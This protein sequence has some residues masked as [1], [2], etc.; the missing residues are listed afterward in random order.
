[1]PSGPTKPHVL[2]EASA[3]AQ[4]L[5]N[6]RAQP[7]G[8]AT[9]ADLN[10]PEPFLKRVANRVLQLSFQEN[11]RVVVA[12]AP[13]RV[14]HEVWKPSA[15][16]CELAEVRAD[17]EGADAPEGPAAMPAARGFR[18][19][20]LGG[21]DGQAR[22]PA[23][24]PAL[25]GLIAL[26]LAREGLLATAARAL[27]L[28]PAGGDDEAALAAAGLPVDLL[29]HFDVDGVVGARAVLAWLRRE[30]AGAPASAWT[31]LLKRAAFRFRPTSPG[32]RAAPDS[33]QHAP[34]LVRLQ[35]SRA[36]YWI[37][38]GDGGSIDVLRQ[39]LESETAPV[40]ASVEA[41]HV[42]ELRRAVADW[43]AEVRSRIRLAVQ[44]LPVSQWAQDAAKWGADGGGP[45]TLM[46]RYASRGE[47]VSLYVPGDTYLAR[48]L[49]KAGLRVAHSP[50]LF[51]GGNLLMVQEPS[52]RRVLLA[53]EAEVLRNQSLGLS[54]D[55]AV[56][57]LSAELGADKCVV[58]PAA[59]IHIDYE[60]SCRVA[61]GRVVAFVLDTGA[62]A[63]L[64]VEAGIDLLERRGHLEA[65]EAAVA[66]SHLAA[67][68]DA[69]CAAAVWKCLAAFS[70]GPGKF[71]LPFAATLRAG[72]Q[73]SGVGNLHRVMAGLD[74]LMSSSPGAIERV[75]DVNHRV[76][77]RS[78]SRRAEDRAS[79]RA[80]LR[81]L[82]WKVVPV[83]G[84][85]QG[86]R[87]INPLNGLHTPW[88]FLMPVY[89]GL[90]AGLDAAAAGV[91]RSALGEDVEVCPVR[92]SESQ[93]RDGALRCSVA[94]L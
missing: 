45:V 13:G 76:Y 85:G 93:R 73:D 56:A 84:I 51:Q 26:R 10:L 5:A 79:L 72:E 82:G 50:L 88:A 63:R 57:A 9:V 59:S 39:V 28:L 21:E 64:V 14:E 18:P 3:E 52:G 77:L 92:T 16:A 38:P 32:F 23:G 65:P 80:A 83:P 70:V 48:G 19:A 41:R 11:F 44:D 78:L 62:G 8:P 40:L 67:G 94:L 35:L 61:D 7:V 60:V 89:G 22:T 46:P 81:N 87:S 30:V 74:L 43:P 42:D 12:D 33:G 86:D 37:G 54:R 27:A 17:V 75:A 29:A 20:L 31:R 6:V 34:S 53:G 91:V 49:V 36:G 4:V 1:M 2:Q 66:R 15:D 55:E 71:P 58:L 47:E 25:V 24:D 90:F 68:R 69:E